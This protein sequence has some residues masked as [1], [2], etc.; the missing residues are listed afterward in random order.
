MDVDGNGVSEFD[1]RRVYYAGQSYGGIYGTEF[2]AV[3]PDVGVGVIN[4]AGGSETELFHQGINRGLQGDFLAARVPSVINS[5]GIMRIG[6]LN[7]RAP[8]Y[9]DNKP[10]RDGVPYTVRLADGSEH[11]IQ[12]PVTNTV[13]GA[14]VIQEVLENR[15][16]VAM[17]GDPLAY[18]PH[19]RRQPLPGVPAK[20]VIYQFAK[21]DYNVPN[22]ST[23]ALLRAGDL[24][25]RA[26][27]YRHDLAH[28]E[29]PRMGGNPHGF[30][31]FIANPAGVL[32]LEREISL[33]A[34]SQIAAFF[35]SDGKEV[36][37]PEPA[38]FFEVGLK[39][40]PEDLNYIPSP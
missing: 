8:Q 18:A 4:V 12:S 31:S 5:P 30:L 23:T 24:A 15:E 11:V 25:D 28:A 35:A 21:G 32:P 36:V 20:S 27:Y 10:L 1:P 13:A 3:E 7:V 34:Q 19:I 17:S 6:G 39:E 2:V 26:T 33:G 16:W 29:E 40:L 9:H 37:H 38:R 14:T 22:P